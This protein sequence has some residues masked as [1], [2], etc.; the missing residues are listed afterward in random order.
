MYK[1]LYFSPTGNT[2]KLANHLSKALDQCAVHRLEES[3]PHDFKGTEHLVV[4]YP[5]HGFNPP[6]TVKRF[7][8]K[9][10]YTIPKVSLIAVGCA[11]AKINDSVSQ[12]LKRHFRKQASE[13]ILD[14]VVDMPLTLVIDFKAEMKKEV[15]EKTMNDMLTY[16]SLIK[17]NT[18]SKRKIS[19][20]SRILNTIGKLESPA[21][22]LFGLE[23]HAKKSCTSCGICVKNCPEENIK[24]NKKMHPKFKFSCSMCLRCIYDCPEQSITPYISKFIPIKG[25]YKLE[26]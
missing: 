20:T 16:A 23:L 26:D 5:I 25:G 12:G 11:R 2:K 3:N 14:E 7:V 9:I 15:I 19:L 6:R 18:I 4:L 1:I 8:K 10:K 21:A 22:R 17:S 24:F 13:I